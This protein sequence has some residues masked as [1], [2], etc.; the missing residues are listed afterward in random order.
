MK[1][2]FFIQITIFMYDIERSS[3]IK[4]FK[5]FSIKTLITISCLNFKNYPKIDQRNLG[6]NFKNIYIFMKL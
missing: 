1:V 2:L 3:N 4:S 5:K 6:I